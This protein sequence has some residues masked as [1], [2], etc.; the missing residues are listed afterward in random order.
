M[1]TAGIKITLGFFFRQVKFWFLVN[2][3]VGG[4]K[5]RNGKTYAQLNFCIH[6]LCDVQYGY[7]LND[8]F[9]E[10]NIFIKVFREGSDNCYE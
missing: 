1:F 6:D 8:C 3:E 5:S 10:E 9:L 2:H 7:R 4:K